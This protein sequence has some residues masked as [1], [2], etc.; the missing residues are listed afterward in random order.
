MILGIDI[1]GTTTKIAGFK[2][3]KVCGVVSVQADDP[4][5]SACGALGKFI[6][7]YSM[8]L[9]DIESIAITGVGADF[10]GKDLFGIPI[11]RVP[12]FTAIGHGGLFLTG[13]G[14]AV[15]VSMGTGTAIVFAEGREIRHIGG[16]GIGGG[17]LIG[18]ARYL[19]N[20]TD[21]QNIVD[22]ADNGDLRNVDLNIS[23]ISQVELGD[24]PLSATASNFGK[25]SDKAGQADIA[26]GLINLICQS[27]GVM[28][29]FASRA[30]N[31]DQIVL[32]GK[33]VKLPQA[34][35]IF[36]RLG[37]MFGKK[38]LIPDYAEYST[39]VGSAYSITPVNLS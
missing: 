8:S 29:V 12:E 11:I 7:Q 15:V 25:H 35:S 24:M 1:G 28:S 38:F 31:V 34:G 23:D 3:T 21:F 13:L 5:T 33:L 2:K 19:L 30:E 6:D 14:K 4:V 16:S 32:T 39:A 22:L 10:L 17:T 27:I 9:K 26:L 37:D 18:L 36:S 20:S